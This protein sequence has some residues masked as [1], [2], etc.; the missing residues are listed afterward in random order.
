MS[1]RHW[2]TIDNR[3]VRRSTQNK[4]RIITCTITVRFNQYIVTSEWTSW[5]SIIRI[6]SCVAS[7]LGLPSVDCVKNVMA[8]VYRVPPS[9]I[10]P[11][12]YISAMNAI[13]GVSRDV[14]WYVVIRGWRTHIIV[15]NVINW[16]NAMKGVRK[17]LIWGRPKPICSTRGKNMALR[18]GSSSY[19]NF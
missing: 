14:A 18:S 1:M 19:M 11:Y 4:Q 2:S 9:W 13:T 15:V 8:F 3:C 5:Q 10:R 7:N 16:R 17:S 12:S 6:L